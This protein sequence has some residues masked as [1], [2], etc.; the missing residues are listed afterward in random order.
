IDH[1]S[2]QSAFSWNTERA[3]SRNTEITDLIINI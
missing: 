2:L 3:F 1:E